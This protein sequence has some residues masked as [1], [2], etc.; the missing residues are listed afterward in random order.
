MSNLKSIVNLNGEITMSLK[1]VIII[2][3]G[4]GGLSAA[5]LLAK[6]DHKVTVIEKNDHPGGRASVWKKD[7]F[8]FDMGPSWYLMP[9]VFENFFKI[10][11]KKP[12]D[13]MQ[14]TRLDPSYR[15]FFDKD[16]FVDISTD[17]EKNMDLFETLEP[18]AKEKM[19]QYMEKS[20]YEY[21][22]AMKDFIYKDYKHLTDFFKPRLIYEGTKLH[23]FEKLDNYAKRYF[24]SEKIR[25]ILEYTIVFLGGSPY[26]SPALYS[27][28]SH[29]DFNMGVWFPKGGIAALAQSMHSLAVEQGAEFIFEEPVEKILVENGKAIGVK[30]NKNEYHADIVVV[31]ADYAWSEMNLLDEKHQSY[32]NKYWEK[33]KIAPSAYLLYLGLDKQLKKFIHHNLYFHP[34][35]NEHFDDI[36]K[37]PKWPV[38]FSYYVSCISKTDPDSA[39]KNGENVFVLIPVAPDL[40]DTAEI[41]EE[42]FDKVIEHM[43]ELS[44]ENIR[45]HIVVKRIFTHSDFTDRY[46][47]YKGTALGLAHTLK[48]TAIFRPKHQSKKV[49]NLYYTGHYNH[50]GIGVPMV[51]IS[52]KIVSDMIKKTYAN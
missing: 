45:D 26:D 46:N 1:S 28:M 11:N 13:Y 38:N 43:E 9:D 22:I 50:P 8:I 3:S 31:N 52:S 25:K 44:Q 47:A 15:V 48:Q 20:E 33:R 17:I 5:A 16:D 39:I 32:T 21:D 27:L 12:E 35:W 51:I 42:Y 2:G 19:K 40:K 23:M 30:T 24:K 41:R 14:L 10:F 49:K 29:V 7:G 6:Q 18:G 37:D 34:S 4:F 36:F